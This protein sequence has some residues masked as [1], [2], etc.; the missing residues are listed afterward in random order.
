MAC[1]AANDAAGEPGGAVGSGLGNVGHDIVAF[2][3]P[4][5]D[6]VWGEHGAA[7]AGHRRTGERAGFVDQRRLGC[8][9]P[10]VASA[11]HLDLDVAAG[12]GAGTGEYLGPGHGDLDGAAGLAGQGPN[13]GLQVAAALS[14]SSKPAADL[15]GDHVHLAH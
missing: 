11:A 10:A 8:R 13:D 5:G 14:L 9:E 15:H 2:D 3:K 12:G 6:V 1:S 7:T 4:I